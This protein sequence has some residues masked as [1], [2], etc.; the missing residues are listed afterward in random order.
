[1][2]SEQTSVHA[3]KHHGKSNSE[4]DR[5]RLELFAAIGAPVLQNRLKASMQQQLRA[6]LNVTVLG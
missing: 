5:S 2:V 3:E 1:M 6:C 4:T